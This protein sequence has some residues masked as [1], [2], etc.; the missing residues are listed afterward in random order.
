VSENDNETRGGGVVTPTIIG[1]CSLYQGDC[2]EILPTL[3]EV[4]AV[5]TSPPYD[6][7]REYGDTFQGLNWRGVILQLSKNLTDGGVSP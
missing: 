3:G 6:D 7:L 4:D 5:V 1:D 2:L